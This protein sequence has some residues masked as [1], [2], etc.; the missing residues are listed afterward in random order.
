V[1]GVS[2]YR[3]VTLSSQQGPTQLIAL[4][5]DPQSRAA[6]HFL[7]GDPA[8]AFAAFE[9]ADAVLI[10]EP[11]AWKRRLSVGDALVLETDTGPRRFEVAAV[12][13]DYGSDAGVMMMS[14]RSYDRHFRDPLITSV[15][16]F[17]APGTDVDALV[18]RVRGLAGAG[19]ELAVRSN[20]A[21]RASSLRVFDRTFEVTAVL[22]LLALLVAAFGVMGALMALAL[23]RTRELGV[24]RALGLTGRQLTG[25]LAAESGLL[26]AITGLLAAP[27]GAVLAALLVF[28]I[29]RRS[30]GWTMDLALAPEALAL[31]PLL[32][33]LAGLVGGLYPALR[34]ARTSPA[35]ALR[36]E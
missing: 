26:G 33:L 28:V 17:A 18:E 12:F 34:M 1:A 21:L 24:L 9:A 19:Q 5:L 31:A 22:R 13:R 3:E 14:R 4:D 8:G 20:R 11:Y 35:E 25:L 29:N 7:K 36:D 16:L 6:F 10:S 30:F 2:T 23:E 27:V 15:A 32:G